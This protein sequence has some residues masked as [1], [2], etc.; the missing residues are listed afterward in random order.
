MLKETIYEDSMIENQEM[1]R[2]QIAVLHDDPTNR[3]IPL[4]KNSLPPF[5]LSKPF[6]IREGQ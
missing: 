3:G 5:Q 1:Q 6:N 2:L 4:I